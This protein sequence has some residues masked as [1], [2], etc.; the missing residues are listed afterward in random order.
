MK[1]SIYKVICI[2]QRCVKQ[3][4]PGVDSCHQRST[5]TP[6][7]PARS[8]WEVYPGI[9]LKVFH[10]NYHSTL[11]RTLHCQ[12]CSS[13]GSATASSIYIVSISHSDYYFGSKSIIISENICLAYTEKEV[14][15]FNSIKNSGML[16]PGL[17]L[18]CLNLVY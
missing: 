3:H 6:A 18:P 14:N 17:F 1:W 12:F 15:F 10:F 9:S 7:I 2:F 4:A 11:P 8:S 13:C 16:R 5:K